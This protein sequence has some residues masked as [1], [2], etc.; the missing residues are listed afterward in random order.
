M[1]H[2]K[3]SYNFLG[4]KIELDLESEGLGWYA[5]FRTKPKPTDFAEA[6][7]LAR[8]SQGGEKIMD[9]PKHDPDFTRKWRYFLG[10]TEQ[11]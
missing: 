9:K 10:V 1:D 2:S 7:N 5:Y 3:T 8:D 6:I 11:R 4:L